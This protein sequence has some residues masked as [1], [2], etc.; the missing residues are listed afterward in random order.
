MDGRGG[1]ATG[2]NV[3]ISVYTVSWSYQNVRTSGLMTYRTV[4]RGKWI[5]TDLEGVIR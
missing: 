3:P 2:L 4:R 5:G 1:V